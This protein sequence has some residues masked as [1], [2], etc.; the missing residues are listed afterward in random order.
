MSKAAALHALATTLGKHAARMTALA[1][2]GHPSSALSLAHLVAHLM[3]RQ[4]RYDLADP[5]NLA[6]DRLILSEGHAIPIVYAAY[7]EL[8][9]V[10]GTRDKP[11]TLTVADLDQL[12][13]RDSVLDGH[14][15][16]AAGFPFFDGA[17]GS[18]GQGLSIAAGLALG[19]R[20]DGLDRRF[21]TII[22][23]G[24]SREGQVWEAA[25][26]VVDYNL[27]NIC[28]IFNCNGQG[29]AGL[30][31]P[32]QAPARMVEKLRAFGWETIEIDGHDPDAIERAFAAFPASKPL[33]IVAKTVK[34]WGAAPLQQ[35]NWHGK[36]PS[37]KELPDVLAALDQTAAKLASGASASTNSKPPRIPADAKEVERPML[38]G[39]EWPSFADALADV[40]LAAAVQKGKVATRAAYGAGLKAAGKLAPQVVALDADVSNSTYAQWFR[41]ACPERFFE[42]KIA[43]QN[44]FSAAVGLSAAGFIPFASTFGKFV[45]RGYDQIEMANISRANIKIVGSH[46]GITLA[47][48]GPSQMAVVDV[49][50][51]RAFTTVASDNR[52]SPLCWFFH[53]ADA[54]SAYAC[55]RLMVEQNGMCYLR[56]LRGEAPLLYPHDAEFRPGGFHVLRPGEDIA[57]VAAGWMTHV[58][59][60]AAE[61]LA[62]QSIRAAVIDAYSFPIEAPRMHEAL[63]RAGARALVAEDNYGGGLGAAIAEVAARGGGVIVDTL[64]CRRIPKSTRTPAEALDYCGLSANHVADHALT[65][66]RRPSEGGSA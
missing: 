16:P 18:L 43:E 51:F 33:A 56:T 23:D 3:Y 32:Q 58:A 13:A 8:G 22:G 1:G 37:E 26:F 60:E 35:G 11:R 66:L 41:D 15:N 2:S 55:T 38:F 63:R 40:G 36:T 57:L 54:V 25:D 31:S 21:Y 34:G 17:T 61:L 12:R 9:G 59:L 45:A 5:W 49:A 39:L 53:P 27:T 52:V 50:F 30:V 29:Q 10:V 46:A 28:A 65:L 24:E 4:M 6:S 64:H 42:C 20:V 48:D 7:A 19:A 44:M 47:A 14:P 62:R